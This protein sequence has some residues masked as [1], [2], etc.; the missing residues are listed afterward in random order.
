MDYQTRVVLALHLGYEEVQD[1][2]AFKGIIKDGK[3]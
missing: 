3:K 1:S 2:Q